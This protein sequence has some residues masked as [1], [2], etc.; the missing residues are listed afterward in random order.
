V[1]TERRRVKLAA[2]QKLDV[3][4]RRQLTGHCADGVTF[5]EDVAA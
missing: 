3:G 1:T 5:D 2:K 4:A